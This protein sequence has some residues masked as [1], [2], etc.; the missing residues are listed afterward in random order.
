[1]YSPN[2]TT[3]SKY[4]MYVSTYLFNFAVRLCLLLTLVATP[5]KSGEHNRSSFKKYTAFH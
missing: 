1:M 3:K 5:M 4:Y 2:I